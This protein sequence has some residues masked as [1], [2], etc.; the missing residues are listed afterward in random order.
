MFHVVGKL[1]ESAFQV[2][3]LHQNYAELITQFPC[4]FPIQ[5]TFKD[6]LVSKLRYLI[7]LLRITKGIQ[8]KLIRKFNLI[9]FCSLPLFGNHKVKFR[10]GEM[11]NLTWKATSK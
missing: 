11:Q 8:L 6:M 2:S 3:N 4:M 10:E 7:G 1:S 9:V 5:N